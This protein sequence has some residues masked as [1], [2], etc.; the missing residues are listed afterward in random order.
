MQLG[1]KLKLKEGP[2]LRGTR[3][4][5]RSRGCRPSGVFESPPLYPFIKQYSWGS[6]F[7]ELV[8]AAGRLKGTA[9]R[10]REW[11]PISKQGGGDEPPDLNHRA[12]LSRKAQWWPRAHGLTRLLLSNMT[13]ILL[14]RHA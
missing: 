9:I 7:G 8:L 2:A 6:Q 1:L 4:V 12:E 13:P 5:Y 11:G 10:T 3:Q 14:D